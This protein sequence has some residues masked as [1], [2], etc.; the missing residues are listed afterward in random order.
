MKKKCD[1]CDRPAT[2]HAIEIVAGKKIETHLCDYH[3]AEAGLSVKSGHTPINQLLTNFVKIHS[4]AEESEA[5]QAKSDEGC[6]E[7]GTTFAE[8]RESS[9]LGCPTCYDAFAE[10]LSPLIG[11][12]HEGAR[13]H[14]GKAPRRAGVGHRRQLQLTRMRRRLDEA[15]QAEDYELAAKLRD[16]IVHLEAGDDS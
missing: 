14:V 12:A 16:D 7:C 2:H 4:G 11:R 5:E 9:L 10:R 13:R 1:K 6:P 8:F 15:V 3:A